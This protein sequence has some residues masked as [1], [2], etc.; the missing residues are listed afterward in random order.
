[1]TADDD[2]SRD[3]LTGKQVSFKG[4]PPQE[5]EEAAASVTTSPMSSPRRRRKTVSIPKMDPMLWGQPGHLTDQEADCYVS[6]E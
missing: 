6:T 3:R 4:L 5:K 1:M 2:W